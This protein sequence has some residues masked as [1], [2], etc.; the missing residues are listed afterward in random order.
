MFSDGLWLF[1]GLADT[2]SR[3]CR[4]LIVLFVMMFSNPPDGEFFCGLRGR[5]G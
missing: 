4:L 2:P 1:F 3:H 5:M